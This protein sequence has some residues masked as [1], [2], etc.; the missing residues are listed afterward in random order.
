MNNLIHLTRRD[1]SEIKAD[2][3]VNLKEHDYH[4][5]NANEQVLESEHFLALKSKKSNSKYVIAL[6]GVIDDLD[7]ED[8]F[9]ISSLYLEILNLAKDLKAKSLALEAITN[10]KNNFDF[11]NDYQ[12][13]INTFDDHLTEGDYLAIYVSKPKGTFHSQSQTKE[14]VSYIT[15]HLD[16]KHPRDSEPFV[17]GMIATSSLDSAGSHSRLA[18]F[19]NLNE[20]IQKNLESTFS[21]YLFALIDERKLK[22]TDVYKKA[23]ITKQV[24]S[25]MRNPL[26][27]PTFETAIRICLSLELNLDDTKDLLG[28][29]G[30]ALSHSKTRDLVIEFCIEKKIYDIYDVNA[31]LFEFDLEEI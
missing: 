23:G 5:I 11:W 14:L 31:Y 7:Y 13:L 28:K 30:F 3:I 10:N 29:A 2:V 12:M 18:R 17:L 19:A 27:Q 25:K 22:D 4:S 6:K 15:S 26:Y 16:P 21:H 20:M 1:L 24:F 9:Y 8:E